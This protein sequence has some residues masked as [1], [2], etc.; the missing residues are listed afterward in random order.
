MNQ[1]RDLVAAAAAH[2][3]TSLRVFGS[4][5]RGE[6]RPDSDLD[7]L[8]DL[9]P[10][11]GLLELGR[12]QAELEAILGTKVDLVPASDLKPAVAGFRASVGPGEGRAYAASLSAGQA[13]LV[14]P[15]KQAGL[16]LVLGAQL[17]EPLPERSRIFLP[18]SERL[19]VP[20]QRRGQV[21]VARPL[22]L[23]QIRSLLPGRLRPGS[24]LVE[25]LGV[26][27][28]LSRRLAGLCHA[29][30]LFRGFSPCGLAVASRL[31][32][33]SSRPGRCRRR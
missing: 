2:D 5:A 29:P 11:I 19:Q 1:R 31:P 21:V 7:L 23:D 25:V 24:E 16:A 18:V 15:V 6:D 22:R 33:L 27:G 14:E 17:T 12:V 3:V 28:S 13:S 30:A 4:V 8:V 9:P 32:Q 26:G 10:D 20:Q